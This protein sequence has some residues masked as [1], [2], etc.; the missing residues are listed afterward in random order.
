MTS[1]VWP[2]AVNYAPLIDSWQVGQKSAPWLESQMNSG[3]D[4][5]R[6][7]YTLP[8]AMVGFALRL[9][10]AEVA[11]FDSF[12]RAD[13]VFGAAKF[14]MPIWVGSAFATRVC[15]FASPPQYAWAGRGFQ[16]VTL[17]LKVENL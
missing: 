10:D 5:R 15:A 17:S 13:L 12:Y 3:T 2:A 16:R 7:K 8:I 4:R 9:S 1:P 14:S 6:A 11:A